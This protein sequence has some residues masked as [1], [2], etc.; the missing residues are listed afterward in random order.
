MH[1]LIASCL[2]ALPLCL[3][4]ARC[5]SRFAAVQLRPEV[6]RDGRGLTELEFALTMLIELDVVK[7][8]TVRRPSLGAGCTHEP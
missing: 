3:S 7:W 4:T 8:E 2:G 5:V 1:L 6:E